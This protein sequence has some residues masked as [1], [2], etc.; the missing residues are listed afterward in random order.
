MND[1]KEQ[2]TPHLP[3][4]DPLEKEGPLEKD[5]ML[6]DIYKDLSLDKVLLDEGFDM[7]PLQKPLKAKLYNKIKQ[8]LNF[9]GNAGQ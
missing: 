5:L 3:A 1:N 9:I 7:F 8:K 2:H 6:H 4:N